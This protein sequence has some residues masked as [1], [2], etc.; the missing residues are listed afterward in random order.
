MINEEKIWILV[1]NAYDARIFAT[2]KLSNDWHLIKEF[3]NPEGRQKDTDIVSDGYGNYRN[4]AL[5]KTTSGYQDRTDPKLYDIDQFAL[6][7]ANE[8]NLCRT[9]NMYNKLIMIAPPK[10]Y[11]MLKK[12]SDEHTLRLVIKHLDKDYAV[13]PQ[14]ELFPMVRKLL[15]SG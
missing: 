10:F 7:L 2:E 6:T 5:N 14:H 11:G 4:N 1:A 8:L 13:L 12:H 9:Q 15:N 3:T